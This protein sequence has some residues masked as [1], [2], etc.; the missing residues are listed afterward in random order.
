M[1]TKSQEIQGGRP[2]Q[3]PRNM[4]ND[5]TGPQGERGSPSQTNIRSGT[6]EHSTEH[7]PK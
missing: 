6:S 1:N 2:S 7:S 3:T 4:G 5:R